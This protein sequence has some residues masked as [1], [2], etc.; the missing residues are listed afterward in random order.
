[1]GR[2]YRH[3]GTVAAVAV[4]TV[5]GAASWQ[6]CRVYAADE[7]LWQD[8]VA[9]NPR[10]WLAWLNLGLNRE[11]AGHPDAAIEYFEQALRLNPDSAEAHNSFALALLQLGRTQ[12]AASHLEQALRVNPD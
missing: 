8:N 11:W 2:Q 12:E 1:M 4:V 3:G 7:K 9:R 10:A 6:R 5:L